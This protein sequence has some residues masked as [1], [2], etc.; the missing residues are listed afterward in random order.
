MLT[1]LSPAKKLDS[2][3]IDLKLEFSIPE[4]RHET[5]ILLDSLKNKSVDELQ[6]I[7]NVSK[8]IAE[9]N[10]KRFQDFD[11]NYGKEYTKAAFY[12][13]KGEVYNG[14]DVNN[15]DAEN[16]NFANNH[17][18]ILSGL[19]GILKPLDLINPYRLEMGSKIRIGSSKNLYEFWQH[20]IT[21]Y[22]NKQNYK[23]IINLASN[24]YFKVVKHNKLSANIITPIF[25]N[26]KNGIYKIVMMHAKKARGLM[27]NYII[28]NQIT[29]WEDLK[30]FNYENYK[31]SPNLSDTNN[32]DKKLVF[33]K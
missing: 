19:Y 15:L 13:F 6:K 33:I 32:I 7:Y 9:L 29:N 26:N 14:L 23:T 11:I 3:R 2:S 4:F 16:I 27:A 17:I 20:N 28:K 25:K 12:M 21:N 22:L 10:Y 30:S 8:E 5:Q 31:F 24:E 18:K 1:L